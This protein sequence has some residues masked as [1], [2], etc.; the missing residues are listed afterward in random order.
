MFGNYVTKLNKPIQKL[1]QVSQSYLSL[2]NRVLKNISDAGIYSIVVLEPI[3]NNSYQYD[4]RQIQDV[5]MTNK[6]IDNTT[7]NLDKSLWA[8]D[9]HLNFDGR[10]EY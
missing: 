2:F 5:L 3:L 9:K 10:I 7:A 4:I 8:D 1:T 6:I